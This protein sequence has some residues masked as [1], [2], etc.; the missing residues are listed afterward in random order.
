[1]SE[2]N[3]TARTPARR[4]IR[5]RSLHDETVTVVR[6]MILDGTLPPGERIAEQALCEE[7]G[8]SRTPL[9]EALKVLASEDLV[10]LM[11]NQGSMVTEVT[12]EDV[13]AMFEM[14]EALEYK[15]GHL[16]ATRATDDDV[17][18]LQSMHE[19][20]LQHHHESRRNE[21][22]DLNQQIHLQ[23]ARCTGNRFLAADYE[24]YLGKIRR[25][26]YLAN[27][28]QARWNESAR[29]HEEIM[30]AIAARDGQKLGD[31]LREH[32]CRTADIVIAAVKEQQSQNAP[33]RVAVNAAP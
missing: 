10:A 28:S 29:E 15:V 19:R 30:A 22:F 21:Y 25:A 18:E 26:R 4:T 6:E 33:E 5:R 17:R 12:L 2:Q 24:D 32:L 9:R 14:M 13:E 20:M 3:D 7:L 11:P 16:A 1:M 8:I 31:C 23:L 27:L